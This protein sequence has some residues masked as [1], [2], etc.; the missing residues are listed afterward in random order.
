MC[1]KIADK[2]MTD[3]IPGDEVVNFWMHMGWHKLGQMEMVLLH[4]TL[5]HGFLFFVFLFLLEKCPIQIN[6][7]YTVDDF[8]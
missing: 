6:F 2:D 5:S 8:N 3:E 1:G 4:D 7:Q